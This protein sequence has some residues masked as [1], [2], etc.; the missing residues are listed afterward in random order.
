METVDVPVKNPW[1][2]TINWVQFVGLVVSA[3]AYFKI[4]LTD[5]QATALLM[6]GVQA[7]VALYTWVKHTWFEPKVLSTSVK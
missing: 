3:A 2:S 6:L 5:A 4:T 1:F 7:G